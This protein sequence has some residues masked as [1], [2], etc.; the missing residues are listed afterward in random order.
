MLL[1]FLSRGYLLITF[2]IYSDREAREYGE[3]IDSK[4][5]HLIIMDVLHRKEENIE[6][7]ILIA[8]IANDSAQ[9]H[10]I[11]IDVLHRKEENL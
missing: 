10:L 7:C 4:Q 1:K 11:L 6:Q 2:A 3:H 5:K 8:M 9:E